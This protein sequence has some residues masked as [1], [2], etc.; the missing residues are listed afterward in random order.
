M[1]TGRYA[2]LLLL[3][4][5]AAGLAGRYFPSS[6]LNGPLVLGSVFAMLALQIL[7]W[8][9]GVMSVGVISGYA[10]L[11]RNRPRAIVIPT[12]RWTKGCSVLESPLRPTAWA[13]R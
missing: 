5:V 1:G 6:I 13:G 11:A 12:G 2:I 3:A 7:G 4:P 8:D 10:Y 9:R